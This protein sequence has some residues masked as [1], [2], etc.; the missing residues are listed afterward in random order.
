MATRITDLNLTTSAAL[1]LAES[2]T[3]AGWLVYWQATGVESGTATLGEVTIVPEFPA[4]PNFLVLP[5]DPIQT[6]TANKVII[7]AFSIRLAAEPREERRAGLGEDLFQQRGTILI[8]GFVTDKAEHLSFATLFRN[9]FREGFSL[10]I[11]DY[12]NYPSNPPLLDSGNVDVWF[13]NRELDALE[14]LDVPPHA[15]YYLNMEVDIVY[16]D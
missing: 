5:E 8:D 6:R 11:R 1:Y 16:F 9:W 13:E 10:P 7:P 4:E 12:E 2:L 15:R 14:L 3:D